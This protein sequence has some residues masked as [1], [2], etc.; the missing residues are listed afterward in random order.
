[1]P[2]SSSIARRS[3]RPRASLPSPWRTIRSAITYRATRSA[4][5]LGPTC[6]LCPP[7]VNELVDFVKFDI[8]GAESG[9]LYE[10]GVARLK[11]IHN[12]FIKFHIDEAADWERLAI[13]IALLRQAEF[14]LMVEGT[15]WTP[16]LTGSLR[17]S[18]SGKRRF[19]R[20]KG[21]V[22]ADCGLLLEADRLFRRGFPDCRR[23]DPAARARS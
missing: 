17:W 19:E 3:R 16:A 7:F 12:M 6:S 11:P 13:V 2:T 20:R 4:S 5:R 14:D 15:S 18:F 1:M 21:S 23:I 8:D 10:M 9:V 22:A